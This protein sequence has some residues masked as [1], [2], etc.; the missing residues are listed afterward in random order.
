[1]LAGVALPL[2]AWRVNLLTAG[3]GLMA[4]VLYLA[5]YTP[6]KPRS[7]A[8]VYV[9]AIPGAT[10]ILMGWTAATGRLELPALTLFSIL[11][12][13]QIPHFIAISLYRREEYAAAGFKILP[14]VY[15]ERASH[16]H[17]LGTTIGL[18]VATGLPLYF[19]LGGPLYSVTALGLASLALAGTLYGLT[20][21]ASTAWA[22]RYFLT[23]LVYL[24]VLLGALVIDRI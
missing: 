15:G 18:V 21:R 1:V 7:V 9:G 16:W 13:W 14:L 8:S 22:R 6:M 4:L 5:V 24:P 2:L 20:P 3:L 12:L 19:D 23:T 11:F 17:M 10:P